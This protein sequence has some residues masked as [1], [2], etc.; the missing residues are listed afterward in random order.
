MVVRQ[1]RV[2]VAVV[3]LTEP[4]QIVISIIIPTLNEADQLQATLKYLSRSIDTAQVEI[5]ISDGG[6]SDSSFDIIAKYPCR[7]INSAVGRARQMNYAASQARG[8]WLLFLHGDSRLPEDWQSLIRQSQDWGFFPLKLSGAHW[9]L[10]IIERA[11]SLRSSIT[12]V[13]TGDQ[14]LFFRR[15]LFNRI[16]GF[17]EIPLMEDIAI[18][19]KARRISKPDIADQVI[20]T[21]SRRW[22]KNGI[23]KTVCLMWWLRLAYWL[24]ASPERLHRI[25]YPDHC[26]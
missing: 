11:V 17:D 10:R 18:S 5:L 4:N 24:G 7:I 22:E 14:A 6:S 25:Y 2:V 23:I 15:S 1:V 3:R 19:K 26:R 21:S 12:H 20:V 13:A 9:L 8:E 16:N